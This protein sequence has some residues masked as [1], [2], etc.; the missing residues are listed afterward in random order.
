MRTRMAVARPGAPGL[1]PPGSDT[2]IQKRAVSMKR[3]RAASPAYLPVMLS[4]CT[5]GFLGVR[6]QC[7]DAEKAEHCRAT[8]PEEECAALDQIV[9][10]P[11]GILLEFFK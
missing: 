9:I 1:V 6:E 8:P 2:S 3:L 5:I 7:A 10:D 4:G 11:W